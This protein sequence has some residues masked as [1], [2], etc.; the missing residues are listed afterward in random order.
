M[1]TVTVE[2][3]QGATTRRTWV[4]A[5][6]IERALQISGSGR[7]NTDARVVFTVDAETL[8]IGNDT[9]Q[10]ERNLNLYRKQRAGLPNSN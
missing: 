7:P 4:S 2:Q 8:W 5:S 6:S 1:I 10:R 3:Q 9:D